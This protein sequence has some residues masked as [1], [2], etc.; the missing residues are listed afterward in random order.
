MN[1]AIAFIHDFHSGIPSALSLK[2]EMTGIAE[3]G[4]GSSVTLSPGFAF[5][6]FEAHYSNTLKWGGITRVVNRRTG[7]V[8][9]DYRITS[10]A[11]FDYTQDFPVPEPGSLVALLIGIGCFVCRKRPTRY[12][13]PASQSAATKVVAN[14]H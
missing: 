3:F 5:A 14:S 8:V 2:L 10:A 1:P 4:D 11:G 6:S 7:E 9:T 13:R 12:T